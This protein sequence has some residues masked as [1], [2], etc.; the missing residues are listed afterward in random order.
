METLRL[1]TELPG[2]Q[3]DMNNQETACSTKYYNTAFSL[4]ITT[5]A[6]SLISMACADMLFHKKG[7]RTETYTVFIHLFIYLFIYLFTQY[8]KRDM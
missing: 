1:T 7:V 6:H 3:T 8:F 2:L 4:A 5:M